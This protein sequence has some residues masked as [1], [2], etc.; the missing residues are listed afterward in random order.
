MCLEGRAGSLLPTADTLRHG[1]R[2][3]CRGV[4]WWRER[5][6]GTGDGGGG[7]LGARKGDEMRR[8][9]LRR[10]QT[11][12]DLLSAPHPQHPPSLS[13]SPPQLPFL[14]L[15]ALSLPPSHPTST[16]L[17]PPPPFSLLPSI[18]P[19]LACFPFPRARCF[20]LFPSLC[21]RLS[22]FHPPRLKPPRSSRVSARVPNS[23]PRGSFAPTQLRHVRSPN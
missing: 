22:P 10:S 23:S 18:L 12:T 14:F 7:S 9:A 11:E 4:S 21:F 19:A 8:D 5:G 6:E 20:A 3:W 17:P 13:P 1:T 2:G 15:F 16:P